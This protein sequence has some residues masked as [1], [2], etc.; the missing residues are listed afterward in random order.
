MKIC[1]I[2]FQTEHLFKKFLSYSN[3]GNR[4][5]IFSYVDSIT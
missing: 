3:L 4:F 5:C 1:C 2:C